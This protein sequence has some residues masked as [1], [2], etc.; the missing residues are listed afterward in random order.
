V[1]FNFD[2]DNYMFNNLPS[3]LVFMN[4]SWDQIAPYVDDLKQRALTRE[5]VERWLADWTRL[6]ELIDEAYSRR[7]IKTTQDT[8]DEAAQH[9]FNEYMAKVIEPFQAADDMLNRK[10]LASGFEVKG[11]EIAR[12]RMQ[13][14]VEI[15]SEANL[16]LQTEEQKL[17]AVYSKIVGTQTIQ[18]EG[19][20]LTLQQINL[21][22]LQDPDRSVREK[23]WRMADA[24][25]LADREAIN[26]NWSKL[27]KLRLQIAK[28]AGMPDYRSFVWKERSRF[29]YT[30][31][32]CKEFHAAIEAVVVP[33]AARL[34]EKRR[35]Q[36]G[37]DS[38][39]PWDLEVDP[40]GR[41]PLRPFADTR[42]LDDKSGTIFQKVDPKLGGYYE[43]MR[44]EKMMDLPNRKGKRPGA[45][46]NGL[47]ATKRPF[48][49]MNA[50]GTADDV[51][52]LLHECGHA[53]HAFEVY[54]SLPYYHQRLTPMEF[55]EVASMAMELLASPYLPI[56]EGGF[57]TPQD[58]ARARIEHL[59]HILTF[60]PYMAVVDSFQ[61]RVYENH[62]AA[63]DPAYCDAVWA[64]AWKRFMVGIDYT[65]LEDAEMTGWHRKQHIHRRPFYYIEYGLAQLGAVQVWAKALDNQ[66]QAVA[67]Y[68]KALSLGG[69]A[70]LPQLY[71]TAGAKFA[72]DAE[73][74][75]KAVH[76][77]ER[78]I[79]ELEAV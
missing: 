7:N 74:L 37:V 79:H 42:E 56:S 67:D 47:D 78:T 72:F 63:V 68:R 62:E 28:N 54:A 69:E 34:Y 52:T 5:N 19:E 61:H 41:P 60:W 75:S 65:G 46:S 10:F 40:S 64:E 23:A 48:I 66:A 4:W 27:M 21:K 18:W 50:V 9:D 76:L 39:R 53:F 13:A 29:D 20:E 11:L 59:E 49:F 45:Y 58:A 33:A 15:F 55:N 26:E 43:T 73:T 2:E 32:D 22:L 8:T 6:S 70:S 16:P 35:Q 3:P 1:L 25:Q 30:P 57:Y 14:S 36:L 71:G 17:G 44:R 77:I 38:L 12:R 31:E 24:R 51:R